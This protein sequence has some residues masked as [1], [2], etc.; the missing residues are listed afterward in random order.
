MRHLL[1]WIQPLLVVAAAAFI[2]IFLAN[3]WPEL[4]AHEWQINPRLLA[5]AA[6]LLLA[7]WAVEI[8]LWRGL[9]ATVGGHLPYLAAARIWFLSAVV[10]YVPG[11]VWQPLSMTLYCQRR[12]IRPEVTVTGVALY[13][14]VILLAAAPIAALY[15]WL[16][17]NW[18]LLT[19]IVGRG[20]TPIL[21]L[22]MLPFVLFIL[23]PDLLL[24]LLNWMLVRV[25][26]ERLN[27]K[28]GRGTLLW[29]LLIAAFDWLLWGLTFAALTFAINLYTP[30]Q[31]SA[32]A[33]HLV[34]AYAIAY[35]VGFL[36]VITPSGFGV[37][38]GALYLLLATVLP[39]T[40]VTVAALAMRV[41]TMAGEI[42]MALIAAAAPEGAPVLPA[43][44]LE[45]RARP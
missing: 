10:R 1:R 21:L 31:M 20:S 28:L 43:P 36:S 32:L 13:Q 2:V 38:E 8:Q 37:R 7:S 45:E 25:G 35:S 34:A 39:G 27:V 40:V 11:N 4:R 5:L 18:G 30:A 17:G 9:L 23:R 14:V 26:R 22:V 42:L 19:D 33:P 44:A 41:W 16:S 15:F 3:Q 29:M 6:L 24:A 12:G